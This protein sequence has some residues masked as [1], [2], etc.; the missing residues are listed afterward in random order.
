MYRKK[1]KIGTLKV[2]DVNVINI[3]ADLL[4]KIKLNYTKTELK[5]I[6]SGIN[7]LINPQ[8][9]G[10]KDE[11]NESLNILPNLNYDLSI[12]ELAQEAHLSKFH[13]QRKFKKKYGLTIGQLK[14]QEKTIKAK[15]LLENGELSTDAAY[16][17]GFFDQSHFTILR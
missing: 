10:Q 3:I 11:L 9:V 15:T 14:Q 17:L 7:L 6:I 12:D 2:I 13:F 8:Q 1:N 5:K 16:E 4:N